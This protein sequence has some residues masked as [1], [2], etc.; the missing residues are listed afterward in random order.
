M[1]TEVYSFLFEI[2]MII[3]SIMIVALIFAAVGIAANI[4][5]HSVREDLYGKHSRR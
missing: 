4:I 3:A 2:L 5:Y 1:N